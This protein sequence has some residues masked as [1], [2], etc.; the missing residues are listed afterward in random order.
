MKTNGGQIPDIETN[1]HYPAMYM[2]QTMMDGDSF[3][4]ELWA[5]I[6]SQK[7]G[8]GGNKLIN[9]QEHKKSLVYSVLKGCVPDGRMLH[10]L[11]P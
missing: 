2:W 6:G 9:L 8:T 5:E 1:E 3:P 4:P 10:S 11:L 7:I